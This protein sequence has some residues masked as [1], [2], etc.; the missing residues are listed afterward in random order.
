M[1]KHIIG[2]AIFQI[3]VLMILVF[4]G[5]EIIPEYE[6]IYDRTIFAS[7]P[8]YKWNDGIVGGTMRSG[9]FKYANG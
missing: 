6:D 3:I 1:F 8:D 7:H 4:A 5:E 9:R 2:Q